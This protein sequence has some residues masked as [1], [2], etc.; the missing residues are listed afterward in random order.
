MKLALLQLDPTV[1]A[2]AANVDRVLAAA[3]E[4]EARGATL[5]VTGELAVTGYPP[6]DLLDRP[7]FLREAR[8]QTERLVRE[9]PRGLVLVVGTVRARDGE[10]GRPIANSALVIDRGAL[11]AHADKQLLPTYDVFDEAR[12]FEPGA[13]TLVVA[14]S[15]GRLAITVCEDAWNDD[16]EPTGYRTNP[17][18]G[19]SPGEADLIVNLSASPF[20]LDKRA[21]RPARFQRIAAR[22]GVPVAFVNQV[23]GADELVFDGRS[24]LFLPDGAVALRAAAFREDVCVG[25]VAPEP[26]CDEEAAALALT[27]GLAG[28]ARK[29]GF[30]GAVLGLSGGVD[31]ALVAT[32]AADALGPAAVLGVAL[33][34]RY[35]SKGSLDDAAAL[36]TNLGVELRQVSI[37]PMFSSY[38]AALGP[39]LDE[40]RAPYAGDVT[41]E[42][43]QARVRGAALM[44]IS[45]RTGKLVLT[46]GNKSELGVGYATLYG[47]MCGGLAVISDVYKTLVWRVCRWINRDGERIPWSSIDKPP[48]AELRPDQR[49]QDSLPPYPVLDEV[50]SLML[51]EGHDRARLLDAGLPADAVDRVLSL[52]RASEYKRRQAAPGIILTKKA[53]GMGRRMPIAHA[54]C[55]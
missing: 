13:R 20:T 5:A 42:N 6:R 33:P 43:V 7:A 39:V 46:T 38:E 25:G 18:D 30:R 15:A 45:N 4:A 14:T 49:D 37:E 9:A 12:H 28:Y 36:A 35:S 47:D 19:L 50:L 26:A 34:S 51:E 32:L 55:E 16:G 41:L 3:R 1:G 40:L 10:P 54:F 11:V 21:S 29:C 8:R 31:S 53:F 17:L 24:A 23:G 2:L 44:A 27:T 52:Y 48:S 22:H